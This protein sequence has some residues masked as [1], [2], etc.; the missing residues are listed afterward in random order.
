MV[1][2]IQKLAVMFIL[3]GVILAA[4][5]GRGTAADANATEVPIAV[6]DAQVV[7]EGRLVPR[8]SVELSFVASGQVAEVLVEEGDVVKAG[9]VLARLGN[10]EQMESNIAAAQLEL[11]AAQQEALDAQQARDTLDDN[12]PQ[13]Q[14][15]ALEAITSARDALYNAERRLNSLSSAADQPDIDSASASVIL[16]RDVLDKAK[17]D[18]E[19][20]VNKPEDNLVRAVFLNKLA[21]AQRA[22]DDAVRRLNRLDGVI[23]SDFDISQ[24]QAGMEIA[25]ARLEQSQQDFDTLQAGP[26]PEDVALAESRMKTAEGRI[27]SAEA[28]LAAAEDALAD[29]D[30]VA[31]INGSVVKLDLIAGEQVT[32]GT[33]V[34]Q[35][36]D[37]S[38]WYVETDNLTEIDV[39]NVSTDQ[40]VSIVPDALPDVQLSG[41]V[42]SI[43]DV[44]E[45]KRGDVTYTARILVNEVDPRLRWGMTV[46]VSFE[47]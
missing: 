25:Q 23:G 31:T 37:F 1:N 13:A 46:V 2:R 24:A 34:V 28:A 12:L 3:A 32:P 41:K 47:K 10:R 9:D 14:T 26:D 43:G 16:A 11:L 45:E 21:E 6:A 17:D 4:C 36:A 29:L 19:P 33:P 22:Y 44:F 39:V 27:Q 35:L 15:Q 30:L 42:E 40:A 18:F 20:Y 8:E 5:G 7:A 38:Q